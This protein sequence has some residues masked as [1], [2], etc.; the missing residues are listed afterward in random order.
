MCF[1]WHTLIKCK[2]EK[3]Y[4]YVYWNVDSFMHPLHGTVKSTIM[5]QLWILIIITNRCMIAILEIQNISHPKMKI[6]LSIIGVLPI[7]IWNSR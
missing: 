6:S 5:E 7:N 2:L 4:P 3:I 1:T